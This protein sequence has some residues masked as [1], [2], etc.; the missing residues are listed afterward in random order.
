MAPT[1]PAEEVAALLRESEGHPMRLTG[2]PCRP[3]FWILD[4]L[5]VWHARVVHA[6]LWLHLLLAPAVA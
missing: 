3:N 2:V 6:K 1:V 5:M 4:A